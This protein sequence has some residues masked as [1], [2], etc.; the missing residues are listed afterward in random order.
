MKTKNFTYRITPEM[1]DKIKKLKKIK[2]NS[3]QKI[4]TDLLNKEIDD[5]YKKIKL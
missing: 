3:L 2:N 5:E 1:Y 4:I